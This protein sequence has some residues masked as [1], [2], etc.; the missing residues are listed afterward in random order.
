MRQEKFDRSAGIL[1]AISS[2]P[3]PYGIGTFGKAAYDFVDKLDKASQKYWQV[4]PLGPTG[5][6]DSPYQSFS[7]FAGNPYFIDLDMLIE[8]QLIEKNFVDSFKWYMEED[9]VDYGLLYQSRF[10]VLFEAYNNA[11]S[12]D[13]YRDTDEYKEFIKDNYFWLEDYALYTAIKKHFEYQSWQDWDDEYK[14][15]KK[16]ALEKIKIEYKEEIEFQKFIQFKF[17]QQ[18]KKLKEYANDKGVEIIGDIPIYVALDSA[19]VWQNPMEFQMDKKLEPKKV[20]GV[21]PDMFSET[22]QLWGNP[23][24]DWDK[25]EKDDFSWWRK[26][27]KYAAKFYDV[28]RIDHFIGMVKYYSIP[29]ED[30]DARGGKYVLGPGMKLINAINE[31]IGDKKIIAEDLGVLM[32]EVEAVLEESGYPG[33]KILEFAFDG[34]RTN[35][36]LP[37]NWDSNTVAY[38]GTHDNDTIMGWLS[39]QQYWELGYLREYV[40][41]RHESFEQL[42]DKLFKVAYESVANVVIFQT[43]DVLKVGNIGRMNLPSSMGTNWRW[44]MKPYDFSDD[45]VERLRYLC[46]IYGRTK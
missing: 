22:G 20:A 41:A 32:P 16:E 33:M 37:Y 39:N 46:D 31:S 27:M 40:E 2:L 18:W 15:R 9:Q 36:N 30:E 26:R 25:M 3:S 28:I 34:N 8:E 43:Q 44:R 14:F 13:D 24:Y 29:A 21:P 5:Y 17:Y 6:G 1:M 19:D 4:L 23:L 10:E 35:V 38:G 7:A 11:K 45:K 42:T 12:L